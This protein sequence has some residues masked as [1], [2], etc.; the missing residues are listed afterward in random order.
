MTCRERYAFWYGFIN[1]FRE[2]PYVELH[3]YLNTKCK[4]I[5]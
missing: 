2:I 3:Q 1:P 5:T 4:E